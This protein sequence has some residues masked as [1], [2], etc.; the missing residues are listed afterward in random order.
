MERK[1]SSEPPASESETT[2]KIEQP[3]PEPKPTIVDVRFAKFQRR[4][5]ELSE[6]NISS[7]MRELVKAGALVKLSNWATPRRT[8]VYKRALE[9]CKLNEYIVATWSLI[10][11]MEGQASGSDKM[12]VRF[13]MTCALVEI[14]RVE[15]QTCSK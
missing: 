14:A 3:V 15:F 8:E 1:T 12:E 2:T 11:W 9:L 4:A 6:A 10:Q 7:Q 13:L 5:Q